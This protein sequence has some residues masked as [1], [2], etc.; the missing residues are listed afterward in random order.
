MIYWSFRLVYS[1]LFDCI[2]CCFFFGLF[3]EGFI[4]RLFVDLGFEDRL[5]WEV[6][7]LC[8]VFNLDDVIGI[9]IFCVFCWGVFVFVV[10]WGILLFGFGLSC[11]NK[12]KCKMKFRI[13][14]ILL[15]FD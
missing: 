8:L 12:I 5:F 2:N 6:C 11:E 10:F 3:L 13:V 7:L 15:N 1:W 14:Y 9:W 4:F